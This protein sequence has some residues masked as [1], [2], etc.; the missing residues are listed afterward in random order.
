MK[1]IYCGHGLLD[2]TADWVQC[3]VCD[4]YVHQKCESPTEKSY[5][6]QFVC[7]RCTVIVI[8]VDDNKDIPQDQLSKSSEK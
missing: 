4:G 6:G 2:E 7:K 1:C 3:D 8:D 5:S